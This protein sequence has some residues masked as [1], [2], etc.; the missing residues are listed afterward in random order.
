MK[1]IPLTQGKEAL[2]DDCD[3]EFLVVC[4]WCV[5][6]NGDG[7][8]YAQCTTSRTNPGG[9]KHLK[10]HR[11]V[12]KLMGYPSELNIDHKNGD[13]LDNR[14]ENLRVATTSQ[15]A[16]N[17][18]PQTNSKSGLKGVSWNTPKRKWHAR[19]QVNKKLIHLGYFTDNIEAAKAYNK[20]AEE[21]FR[22][23]AWLNPIPE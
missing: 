10:M 18:G 19:I 17:R 13:G 9:R 20:A 15:N 1:R 6:D 2:V 22:E 4:N 12:S 16:A 3:Y 14:R 21:H 23:F 7:N 5:S 11:V 8:L